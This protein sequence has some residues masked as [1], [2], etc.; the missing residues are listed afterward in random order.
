MRHPNRRSAVVAMAAVIAAR[1]E[2]ASV[3]WPTRAW[4]EAPPASQGMDA[5]ALQALSELGRAAQMDSLLVAR[6]GH[7]VLETYYE[8][9]RA[10]M[11]HR[12]NSATKGIVAALLGMAQAQGRL[13]G[14]DTP[15]LD[16]FPDRSFA[17][18]NAAKRTMTL[19][20]LLDMQSGLAW[21]EPL[22][23]L[24]PVSLREMRASGDWVRFVLDRPM[25]LP[26]GQAFNYNSGNSHLLSAVLAR[27]TGMST[28]A[29]ARQQLFQPLGITDVEWPQDPQG[30]SAGG[31]GLEMT[32]RDMARIGLLVQ[33]V[34]RWE[35]R[36]LLPRE[37]VAQLQVSRV[38]MIISA[39]L[40]FRYGQQWWRLPEFNAVMA[41]GFNR[42]VILAMP[43][44]ELVTVTTGRS[45][46]D[47]RRVLGA[48]RSCV[49]T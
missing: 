44:L 16:H 47:F 11:R 48:L 26:P 5:T 23:D 28:E 10:E 12:I 13:G 43:D 18:V 37:W 22:N 27:A 46:W 4:A 3:P 21:Q 20:H 9:F 19:Q 40:D 34:G 24:P 31:F 15:V 38:P 35:D 42:Q 29:Y 6:R 41:V 39:N 33:Q 45:H 2:A 14:N 36:Q 1:V 25:A 8:P 7:I 32:T 49:R 30:I 17:N